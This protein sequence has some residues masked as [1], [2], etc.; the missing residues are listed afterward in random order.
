MSRGLMHATIPQH[1]K[2]T[3]NIN[4][5][6]VL[7]TDSLVD[8][9]EEPD[10]AAFTNLDTLSGLFNRKV[11]RTPSSDIEKRKLEP[12]LQTGNVYIR[13]PCCY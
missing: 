10:I 5:A 8:L 9:S 12:L 4:A 11:T 2:R 1:K 6:K 3:S 7:S 13:N